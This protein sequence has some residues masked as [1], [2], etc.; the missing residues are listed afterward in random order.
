MP[1]EF[2]RKSFLSQH[3]WLR[4]VTSVA[5]LILAGL[6]FAIVG[7]RFLNP[8]I[9][10]VMIS[11]KLRGTTFARHWVPLANISPNLPLAVIASEDGRFCNHWGV[12][13]SAVK[14]AVEAADDLSDFRG[15]STIPMQT[16][17]NLYL[18]SQRSYVRKSLEVPLAYLLSALWP[19]QVVIET[20]L[21]VAPWGPGIVGVEAASR[22]YF[23]KS[24]DALT[25]KESTLL[26]AALP[27]PILRNPAKPSS[28]MLAKAQWIEMNMQRIVSRSACVL[29]DR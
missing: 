6:L 28:R 27:S 16:V 25:L 29:V 23:N 3:P 12:D 20:Y 26:A 19:K 11:E 18:W 7:F 10:P 2:D 15:A 4:R 14:E 17:K 21:N 9:T 13:W 22:Y 24:A 5:F 1:R 8:A